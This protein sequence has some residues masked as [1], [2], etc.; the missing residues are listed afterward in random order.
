MRREAVKRRFLSDGFAGEG[1][2]FRG[3][4]WGAGVAPHG[5]FQVSSVPLIRSRCMKSFFGLLLLVLLGWLPGCCKQ[6]PEENSADLNPAAE[7]LT[8]LL[9]IEFKQFG[10]IPPSAGGAA[11]TGD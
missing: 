1:R 8:Q 9:A 10:D 5:K 7:R 3:E 11:P 4:G 6:E 2:G